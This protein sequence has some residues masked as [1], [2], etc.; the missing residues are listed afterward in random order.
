[1]QLANLF[2]QAGRGGGGTTSKKGFIKAELRIEKDGHRHGLQKVVLGMLVHYPDFLDEKGDGI[3]KVDF[4]PSMEGFRQALYDLLIMNAELSV[5]IIYARLTPA[6]YEILQDIHGERTANRP[7]GHRLFQR[8]PI[9]R[10]DPP[11]DF[12]SR[13]IDHLIQMLRMGQV[14]DEINLLK[15]SSDSDEA[16]MRLLELVRDY[17][18]QCALVNTTDS[19]LAEEAKEIHRVALGTVEWGMAA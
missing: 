16:S 18:V 15:N 8:F 9:L 6:F 5:Q 12:V 14:A 4:S 3:S 13:C 17:Q 7:W 10:V 1:M 2:W 19:S 11:H